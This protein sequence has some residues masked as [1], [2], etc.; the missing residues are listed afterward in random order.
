VFPP[1]W[2]F[3]AIILLSPLRE[4]PA[5]AES[6]TETAIPAWMPEKTEEER[7]QMIEDIRKVELKWARRCMWAFGVFVVFVVAV[8]GFTTWMVKVASERR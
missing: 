7:R 8:V 1:F 5:L 6:E 4:P 2:F 3:G